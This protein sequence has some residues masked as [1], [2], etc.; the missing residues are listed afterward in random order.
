VWTSQS[1]RKSIGLKNSRF[2]KE[3]VAALVVAF[4]LYKKPIRINSSLI[5]VKQVLYNKSGKIGRR[6]SSN[7]PILP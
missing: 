1:F 4:F 6:T 7:K 2:G 5:C 3:K